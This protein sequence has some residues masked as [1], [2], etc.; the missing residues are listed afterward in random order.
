MTGHQRSR[1]L[2][3]LLTARILRRVRVRPGAFASALDVPERL[4]RRVAVVV[5]KGA[6]D[7]WLVFDCPC[8]ARHRVMLNL[9]IRHRPVWTVVSGTP[10]TLTPSVDETTAGGRCHYIVRKG[11]VEWV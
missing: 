11:R 10:L 9:D 1:H 4:P 3:G 8:P 2:L 7:Q 5:R 6:L